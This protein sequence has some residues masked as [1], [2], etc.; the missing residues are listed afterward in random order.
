MNYSKYIRN[1]TCHTL[2]KPYVL[3]KLRIEKGCIHFI[4]LYWLQMNPAEGP[5]LVRLD[6]PMSARVVINLIKKN[7][8][9]DE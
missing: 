3:Y 8:A 7:N 5:L 1:D 9:H 4:A 6:A 2:F